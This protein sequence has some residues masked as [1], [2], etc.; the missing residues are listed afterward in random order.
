MRFSNFM[1]GDC[2]HIFNHEFVRGSK[3]SL[4]LNP[5]NPKSNIFSRIMTKKLRHTTYF[6]FFNSFPFSCKTFSCKS[7]NPRVSK[8]IEKSLPNLTLTSRAVPRNFS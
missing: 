7:A 8:S 2:I 5:A 4:I 3:A 6:H 1:N